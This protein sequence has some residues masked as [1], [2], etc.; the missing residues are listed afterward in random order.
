M[1]GYYPGLAIAT[2]IF[3]FVA[4]GVAFLSPG[5][6]RFLYPV[7]IMLLLLAGYQFAEVAVCANPQILLYSRL[8]F[9]E[10]TWLPPLALWL[11]YQ[12]SSTKNKWLKILPGGYFLSGLAL[13]IWIFT[14]PS[15]ITKSVCELVIA[16]YS[17]PSPFDLVYGIYFQT[18]LVLLVFWASAALVRTE[19]LV[20]RK[21]LA[22]LQTGVLG[23]IFPS[24]AV[25]I[26]MPESSGILPSVMCHF[27]LIL[28]VSLCFLMARERKYQS[29]HS[30][31]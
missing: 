1:I 11:V 29:F 19:D 2:G 18:G 25:R 9:F 5:R 14:D 15:C 8:A 20:I 23:F 4:A 3:E 12:L 6:K 27:A 7:G 30:N 26:L 24:M 22:N 16:R 31:T 13:S 10:I 17:H 21:H 28:A